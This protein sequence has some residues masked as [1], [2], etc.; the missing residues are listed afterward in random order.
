MITI[1][2]CIFINYFIS[3]ALTSLTNPLIFTMLN[4]LLTLD[5]IFWVLILLSVTALAVGLA[6]LAQW[7]RLS[8][9]FSH[10]ANTAVDQQIRQLDTETESNLRLK[11]VQAYWRCVREQKL[12]ASQLE[13]EIWRLAKLSIQPLSKRLKVLEVIATIAPLIG[14]LGTVLGMVE[15]FQAMELAGAQV[16]PAVLSG[17]IWK[18]LL[19]TAAGLVI[20]IPT[21]VAHSWFESKTQHAAQ[22][23]QN[24]LEQFLTLASVKA[25]VNEMT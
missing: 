24:D 5:P 16:D 21:F 12:S 1:I 18:A 3:Y 19:T 14:L 23:I 4:T 11:L 17:G 15:A 8:P 10:D 22:T 13:H 2:V 9:A 7:L 6:N 20:A 25:S